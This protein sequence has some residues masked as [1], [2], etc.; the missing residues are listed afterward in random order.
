ML[1]KIIVTMASSAAAVSLLAATPV[2]A[3]DTPKSVTES[4]ANRVSHH[5]AAPTEKGAR[6]KRV[7]RSATQGKAPSPRNPTSVSES[8]PIRGSQH[9]AAP[10]E[11]AGGR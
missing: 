5:D 6:A 9:D 11:R 2:L 10:T 3:D 7:D 8:G 1:R 4:G